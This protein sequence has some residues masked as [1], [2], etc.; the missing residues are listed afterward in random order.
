M[1]VVRN[2]RSMLE[3]SSGLMAT[4][5]PSYGITGEEG[6]ATIPVLGWIGEA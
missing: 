6:A 5:P 4:A 2:E 1:F 3:V